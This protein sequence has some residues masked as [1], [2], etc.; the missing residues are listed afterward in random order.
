ML[1]R[2]ERPR[3]A[4]PSAFDGATFVSEKRGFVY[5]CVPKTLSRSMLGYLATTDPDGFRA[6]DRSYGVEVLDQVRDATRFTFVRNPY[7]RFVALYY[8]K[9]VNFQDSP[10][11]RALFG[12]DDG[13]RPDMSLNELAQ[14]LTSE[15]KSDEWVDAHF[16]SQHYFVMDSD[17]APAVDCVG[18]MESADDDVAELQEALGLDAEPLPRINRNADR[19]P[20]QFDTST[21]WAE[22]LDDHTIRLLSA[23]YEGD[24]E[25][26]GYPR[27]PYRVT[28]RFPRRPPSL[29]QSQPSAA[30]LRAIVKR[31]ILRPLGIEVHRYRPGRP[32]R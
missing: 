30:R 12:H 13:L 26:F 18:R 28:P 5:L 21:R 31:R 16:V 14:W 10:G 24:F 2:F 9:F 29:A 8:D 22:V 11:Q 23:R 7:S 27:L 6:I 25:L 17:G 1:S 15:A 19:G 32:G 20:A 4:V 3:D